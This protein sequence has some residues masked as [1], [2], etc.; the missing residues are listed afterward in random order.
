L[1]F[2]LGN[3]VEGVAASGV[4]TTWVRDGSLYWQQRVPGGWAI[5]SGISLSDHRYLY[6]RTEIQLGLRR[7]F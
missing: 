7:S 4:V 3:E 6:T 1:A 2:A 5:E